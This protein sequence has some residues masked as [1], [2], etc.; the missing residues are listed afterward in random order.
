[1]TA[2]PKCQTCGGTGEIERRPASEHFHALL[3]ICPKCDGFG[4][5]LPALRRAWRLWKNFQKARRVSVT[6]SGTV[7]DPI[8][9]DYIEYDNLTTGIEG[10][11]M[12]TGDEQTR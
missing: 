5:D 10:T 4:Y 3:D 1:M 2:L 7:Y 6:C 12:S 11:L 8:Y 9:G